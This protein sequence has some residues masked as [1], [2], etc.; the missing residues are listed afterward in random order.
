MVRTNATACASSGFS[1][2]F[3][4]MHDIAKAKLQRLTNV[5]Y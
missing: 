1:R 4:I 3:E 5:R 2:D